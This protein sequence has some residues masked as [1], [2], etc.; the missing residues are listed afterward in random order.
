MTIK[1][2]FDA[3][4]GFWIETNKGTDTA[5]L[6]QCVDLWRAYNRRV[7]SAPDV[8]GNAVDF[9]NKYPTDFYDKIPNTPSGVPQ[10]GDVIVWGTKYGKYGHIAVCTDIANIKTFTSFDQNDPFNSPCHFQPHTYTG[11]LGWLR[12]KNQQALVGK[13]EENILIKIL[14]EGF[15]TLPEED[16]LKKGN[17][18]G[19]LRSIVDE[20]KTPEVIPDANGEGLEAQVTTL[21]DHIEDI[22]KA[23]QMPLS[24][25][26]VDDMVNK[27]T[28]LV[29]T[30][31][32]YERFVEYVAQCI[33][34]P[35]EEETAVREAL[36]GFASLKDEIKK[37]RL[38]DFG[39]WEKITSGIVDLITRRGVKNK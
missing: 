5:T 24:G 12:P 29:T 31:R 32:N 15:A 23:L 33:D 10:L 20:H 19:Y 11:V 37:R 8:Y 26:K 14:S 16:T 18:E 35:K 21:K 38:E 28:K 1:E 36:K 4:L 7:I 34:S 13:V 25:D 39:A 30:K 9:W 22:S 17:L 27:I 2:F 3:Y 6:D